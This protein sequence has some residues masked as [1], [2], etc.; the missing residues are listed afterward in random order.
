M[1]KFGI[2]ILTI[3]VLSGCTLGSFNKKIN[4]AVEEKEKI[5]S[6]IGGLKDKIEN[7]IPTEGEIAWAEMIQLS[8][9][10]KKIGDYDNAI[11][12]YT[13]VFDKGQKTAAMIHNLGRLYEDVREYEKA[14][15]Q[16]K[17]LIDE[18]NETNYLYDITWAY[19]RAAQASKGD[20]AI[21]YRKEAEKTFNAWQLEFKKTDEQTQGAIKKLRE[22]EKK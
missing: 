15:V 12:V 8:E 20:K 19:I 7:Y 13:D 14:I 17:R 5:K 21:A 11:K 22:G 4:I 10:Y 18:Y 2:F 16:Y 6:E 3:T 9:D 1:K